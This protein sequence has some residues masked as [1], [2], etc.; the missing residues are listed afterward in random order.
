MCLNLCLF[1]VS[2]ACFC[3]RHNKLLI[4]DVHPERSRLP[5]R[6]HTF[7]KSTQ[8]GSGPSR[9]MQAAVSSIW[10]STQK[11]RAHIRHPVFSCKEVGISF[12]RISSLNGIKS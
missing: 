8:R 5:L 10:T 7:M 2:F 1:D 12:T 11:I 4:Y 9:R 6:D 3:L